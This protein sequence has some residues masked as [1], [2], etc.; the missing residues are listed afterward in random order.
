MPVFSLWRALL[1]G[2]LLL[3]T[4]LWAAEPVRPECIAPAAP[5]G[6]FDLACRLARSSLQETG[7]LHRPL[8][9]SYMP[10]GVGAVAYNSIVTQRPAEGGTLVA[11]STGSLLNIAQS[12]FGRFDEAAVR[13]LAVVGT[14]YGALAVRA[15]SPYRNLKDL[16]VD[17]AK[18]PDPVV[19]GISGNIGGQDWIQMALLAKAAG[20]NPRRLRYVALEGGGEM[21]TALIGGQIQVAS[22]DISDSMPRVQ[23]GQIRILAVFA[24]HRF[25]EPAMAEIPTAREQGYDI[26]WPVL[27]GF[28]MGP[29]VSDA[30]YHWWKRTFDQLLAS[31]TFARLRD[32]RKLLPLSLTGDELTQ[33]V[34]AEVVRYQQMAREFGLIR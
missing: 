10:G 11:F 19:I 27:R 7:L 6:G 16:V 20:L 4:P 18:D 22:S 17:L 12:K 30:D 9:I 21:V 24:K 33:H 14:S 1:L 32:E 29:Q 25:D 8:A 26:V 31:D 34:Q 23:S 2:S 15:D 28:Y 3:S 5:G 13:W